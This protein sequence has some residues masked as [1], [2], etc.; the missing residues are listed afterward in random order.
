M[1]IVVIPPPHVIKKLM[2]GELEVLPLNKKEWLLV[3]IFTPVVFISVLQIVLLISGASIN[4]VDVLKNLF[5]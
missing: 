2:D 1:A 3:S 4:V 5:S